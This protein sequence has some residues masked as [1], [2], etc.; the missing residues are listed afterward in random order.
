MADIHGFCDERFERLG[1]LFAANQDQGV[2]E[3]ASLAVT[4]GGEFVVDMWA[5]TTDRKRTRPWVENTLVTVF[6]TSKVMVNIAVLM[7]YD[8]GLLDLD[9]PIADHWPEFAQNGK[10]TI[11]TRQV[12]THASGLPGFGQQVHFDELHDWDH[13][14]GILERAEPWYKPGSITYYHPVTYGFLLGEVVRRVSGVSFADFFRQEI[15]GPLGADFHFGLS[16]PDDLQR[17]AQLWHIDPADLPDGYNDQ[18][19]AELGKGN[20]QSPSRIAAVVP[21]A[22][23]VGNARSIARIGAII[24]MG[25]ELDG[26][27]YLSPETVNEAATEQSFG[28]D[29]ILGLVRYGLGFGLDSES[30]P[31]PTLTTIHWGGWG[32][33]FATMDPAAGISAG[34]APNRLLSDPDPDNA[35]LTQDRQSSLWAALGAASRALG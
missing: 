25:G 20:S 3:G 17:M 26:R 7:L 29:H 6:S 2:D 18:V 32:G 14:I 11:T 10:E 4:L 24:A 1:D 9:A 30:Y 15:S 13:M 21:S 34:F 23:G 22:N 12:L 28:H 35:G 5:G 27:R 31:A 19:L 8:R 16:S 33:S